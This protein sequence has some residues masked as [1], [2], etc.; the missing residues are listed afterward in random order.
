MT[1]IIYIPSTYSRFA[2]FSGD[3]LNYASTCPGATVGRIR[4]LV[5]CLTPATPTTQEEVDFKL[6]MEVNLAPSPEEE[7]YHKHVGGPP[8]M[9]APMEQACGQARKD[10]RQQACRQ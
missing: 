8:H 2:L 5:I 9:H 1:L 3:L 4:N 6:G 10:W 7:W